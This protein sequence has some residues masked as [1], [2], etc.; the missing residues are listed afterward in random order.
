MNAPDSSDRLHELLARTTLG[1]R[2][3]FAALY[4]ATAAKLYGVLLR[5]LRDRTV[6]DDALQEVFVRVWQR[7][8]DY[9]A[10]RGSVMTWLVSI[11]RHRAIDQLRRAAAGPQPVDDADALID[12]IAAE[13]ED[14]LQAAHRVTEDARLAACLGQLEA[15]RRACLVLAYGDGYTHEELAL[16]LGAPVGTV[17]SWIRRGLQTL[18][19]C[20]ERG[21]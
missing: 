20:L 8:G 18:R 3:A 2:T 12:G 9:H 17:K 5:I 11:A 15:Q 6:A 7:A 21:E 1:D 13:G 19:A 14:P 4:Q 10:G 16:R